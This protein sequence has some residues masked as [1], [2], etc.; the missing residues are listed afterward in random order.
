MGWLAYLGLRPMLFV[1]NWVENDGPLP[2]QPMETCWLPGSTCAKLL[3]THREDH[4]GS[5]EFSCT[6]FAWLPPPCA[7]AASPF[8][9]P[10]RTSS[11]PPPRRAHGLVCL[12][13]AQ[14]HHRGARRRGPRHR[15]GRAGTSRGGLQVSAF[16]DSTRWLGEHRESPLTSP[17]LL[18]A[19]RKRRNA[20]DSALFK[21][22]LSNLQ[23]EKGVLTYGRLNLTRILI[24]V[25]C[26]CAGSI[27][28]AEIHNSLGLL[29]SKL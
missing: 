26:V 12:G 24:Q 17:V 13:A 2:F 18:A 25:R 28:R 29:P 6:V 11:D 20:V 27:E 1:L 15:R 22:W 7:S 3:E 23:S 9:L 16:S 8:P 14:H 10:G 5:G 19:T 21:Q 4:H